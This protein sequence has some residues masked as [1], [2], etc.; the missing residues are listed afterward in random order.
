MDPNN[1]VPSPKNPVI[2]KFFRTI[3]RAD[4]L[5]SGVRNLFMYTRDYSAA[6]PQLIEGDVFRTIVP[7]NNELMISDN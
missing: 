4:D 3:G 5:G 6:D 7:F 1:F 2:A